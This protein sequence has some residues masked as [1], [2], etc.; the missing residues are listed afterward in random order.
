[1][2]QDIRV[3]TMGFLGAFLLA[4]AAAT[5]AFFGMTSSR[6]WNN[7]TIQVGVLPD[8][9]PATLK[10][11]F[12]PLLDYLERQTELEFE[13]V[14]PD[15]YQHLVTLFEEGDV[16][17]A[18]FGGLT[19]VQA[20]DSVGAVPLVMRE[21]D[22]RFTT[23]LVVRN[24]DPWNSCWQLACDELKG[25]TIAFGSRLSTSGHLMPRY[26]LQSELGIVPEEFF[27]EVEYT[28]AHDKTAADVLSGSV[29]IGAINS[30][31]FGAMST[32]GRVASSAL[33]SIWETPPL[34]ELCV[35]NPRRLRRRCRSVNA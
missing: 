17:L 2:N 33:F 19:F 27:G 20:Q 23:S 26:F 15:D 30:A 10:A 1:M 31:I 16:Q 18:Y 29:D 3:K 14:L 11:N 6:G 13:L 9:N 25:T 34:C 7:E 4:L 21:T 35:G 28:G 22:T 32:D 12:E 24:E 5:A 8:Q